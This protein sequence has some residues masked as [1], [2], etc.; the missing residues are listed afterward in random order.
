MLCN[1]HSDLNAKVKN[2]SH[3]RLENESHFHVLLGPQ[4]PRV[5][6]LAPY[7]TRLWFAFQAL[8]CHIMASTFAVSPEFEGK[9]PIAQHRL[10]NSMLTE[11][12]DHAYIFC[13]WY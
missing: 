2:E 1:S 12:P 13:E 3:G 5:S 7:H 10:V 9:K 11:V 6:S 4:N 8:S